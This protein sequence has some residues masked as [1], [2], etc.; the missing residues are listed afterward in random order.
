M[1]EAK[2]TQ[3]TPTRLIEKVNTNEPPHLT[4]EMLITLTIMKINSK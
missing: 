3:E 1:K 4:S 2:V